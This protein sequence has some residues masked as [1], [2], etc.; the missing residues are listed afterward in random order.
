MSNVFCGSY[1]VDYI[2]EFYNW[3]TKIQFRRLKY[4]ISI[5]YSSVNKRW[6]VYIKEKWKEPET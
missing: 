2:M 1:W 6:K 5:V 3:R 4:L